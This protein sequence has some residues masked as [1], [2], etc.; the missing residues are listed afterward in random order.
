MNQVRHGFLEVSRESLSFQE[1]N[2]VAAMCFYWA[3][4]SRSVR[5]EGRVEKLSP[6]ESSDYFYS[7][8]L[9]SQISGAISA[10][11]QPIPSRQVHQHAIS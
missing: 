4:M 9:D 5:I 10:Q 8:P 2:P 11:S 7:R 3:V 1:D 6:T